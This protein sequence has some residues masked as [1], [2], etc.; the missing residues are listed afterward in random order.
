MN[1]AERN[2]VP[3][4]RTWLARMVEWAFAVAGLLV[5]SDVRGELPIKPHRLIVAAGLAPPAAGPDLLQWTVFAI[6]AVFLVVRGRKVVT[7]MKAGWPVV[8]LVILAAVS[9]FWSADPVLSSA[10]VVRIAGT[11]AFGLF[12]ASRFTLEDQL[13]IAASTLGILALV[14]AFLIFAMPGYG[15]FGPLGWIGI[16]EWKNFFG[17]NMV[18]AMLVFLLLSDFSG[19]WRVVPIAGTLLCA[20]LVIGSRS[21]AST[22]T[23]F[24]SLAAVGVFALAQRLPEQKRLRAMRAFAIAAVALVLLVATQAHRLLP[25]FQG[26]ETL[27]LRM[28]L[29]SVLLQKAALH[30]WFGYGYGAFWRGTA[31]V[32]GEVEQIVHFYPYHAHN[33]FL[34]IALDLGAIGF[35]VF[36]LPLIGYVRR[37]TRRA[38]ARPLLARLWPLTLLV[39]LLL[40]NQMYS[41]LMWSNLN[42]ALYVAAM[43]SIMASP[44]GAGAAENS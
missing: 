33:G 24:A 21:R 44:N 20:V 41:A 25:Y 30:P 12:L 4:K 40:I 43:V 8:L 22:F 27:N 42:W 16:F 18:L 1:G 26:G 37:A 36:L 14:S 31:G 15:K 11:T 3:A 7:L 19:R 23:A 32:S 17:R 38:M 29:W 9:V 10:R 35:L 6:T 2:A 28:A 13:R 34:E 5:L 39:Y